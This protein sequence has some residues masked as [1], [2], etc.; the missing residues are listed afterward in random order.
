MLSFYK[1]TVKYFFWSYNSITSKNEII[2]K[3]SCKIIKLIDKI[4]CHIIS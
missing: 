4:K 1:A 3:N 2:T